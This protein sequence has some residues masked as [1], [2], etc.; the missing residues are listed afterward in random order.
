M[1]PDLPVEQVHVSRAAFFFI[2]LAV[3]TTQANKSRLM[4]LNTRSR[5]PALALSRGKKHPNS[6]CRCK[7]HPSREAIVAVHFHSRQ[8]NAE[9]HAPVSP[10]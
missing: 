7:A 9:Q 8:S 1:L 4:V 6:F 2:F 5:L 10:V 3:V